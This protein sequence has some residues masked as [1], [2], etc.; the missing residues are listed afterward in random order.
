MRMLCRVVIWGS[1]ATVGVILLVA[2]IVLNVLGD[3]IVEGIIHEKLD[4]FNE[5]SDGYKYF[6]KPPVPV[7]VN[8]TFFEVTNPDKVMDG[9]IPELTEKGPYV[10][11]EHREKRNL[12]WGR[13]YEEL[14]SSSTG[15]QFI[16]FGQYKYYTFDAE[17]SCEGC[18]EDDEVTIANMPLL[19]LIGKLERMFRDKPDATSSK[20]AYDKLYEG[21]ASD[22][23]AKDGTKFGFDGLFFKKKVNDFIFNGIDTGTAGWMLGKHGKVLYITDRLP[24]TAF[25]EE[26][27]FA[28]F[29]GRNDTMENE[30]YEVETEEV[31]WDRRAM[32]TKWGQKNRKNPLSAE[33]MLEDLYTAY[34]STLSKSKRGDRWWNDQADIEG[35]KNGSNTCNILR[36]TDGNQFP[37]YVKKEENLWIFNSAPCR[38]IFVV[39]TRDVDILGIPTL[40]YSVPLDGANVNKTINTCACEP[41]SK[42][43][44][45][46]RY[47][48]ESSCIKRNES[49]WD[50]LDLTACGPEVTEGCTDGI[51]DLFWCQGAA[52]TLS[53]PHFYLAEAQADHFTGL[54]PDKEKHRLALN[55]E[56]Y[57]GMTLKMHSRIQL[58]VPLYNSGDLIMKGTTH[59]DKLSILDKVRTIPHFPV[60]WIDLGADI[61][62][63]PEMVDKLYKELVMPLKI[64]EVGQW[65][66]IGVGIAL[67]VIAGFF[68]I[69]GP[70][71]CRGGT[72]V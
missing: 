47:N 51:Q 13:Q 11:I 36:G 23:T 34:A 38:S 12:T 25:D 33:N 30:W 54:S 44:L 67:I 5:D 31:S 17:L 1:I 42:Y 7:K 39:Y 69:L 56:P 53:Y 58:N 27:G 40:E 37:P 21:F 3:D 70:W 4:L 2:G 18:K 43:N 50:T 6:I 20:G 66:A 46:H 71:K 48:D 72:T 55:V 68:S 24:M 9:E 14:N 61:E 45:E 15:S 59:T 49:D 10:F 63:D 57:T 60:L 52:V 8:F 65:V 28:M 26:K 32:I 35:I 22:F 16:K 41:L 29:N 19:G 64:L 62:S